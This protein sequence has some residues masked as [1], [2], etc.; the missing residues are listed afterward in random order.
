M[1]LNLYSTLADK[2]HNNSQKI[3]VLTESWVNKYIYCPS[4]GNDISILPQLVKTTFSKI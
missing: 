2:Y 1:G 4:C 3:R